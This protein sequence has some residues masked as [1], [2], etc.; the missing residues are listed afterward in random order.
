MIDNQ[1]IN[2]IKE[3]TDEYKSMLNSLDGIESVILSKVN[4]NDSGSSDTSIF[5]QL[6]DAREVLIGRIKSCEKSSAVASRYLKEN[7]KIQREQQRLK[8]QRAAE[9]LRLERQRAAEIRQQKNFDNA[10]ESVV[11]E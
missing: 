11:L 1:Y 6:Y 3:K 10:V 8:R 9:A 2:N 4:T 5:R 7:Q